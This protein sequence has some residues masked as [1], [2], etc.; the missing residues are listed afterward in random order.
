[1][2][3]ISRSQL[4]PTGLPH[5]QS[6]PSA[7]SAREATRGA[8]S[9]QAPQLNEESALG[10]PTDQDQPNGSLERPSKRVRRESR[11]HWANTNSKSHRG[12]A[13]AGDR[14]AARTPASQPHGDPIDPLPDPENDERDV[15]DTWSEQEMEMLHEL[16]VDSNPH[17]VAYENSQ[18]VDTLPLAGHEV[19][20]LLDPNPDVD[21]AFM[22]AFC[23][24]V[25]RLEIQQ[26]EPD[27]SLRPQS[28]ELI[29][30]NATVNAA[31]MK[32]PL[33]T[34]AANTSQA[35]ALL[36][37]LTDL[38][39]T[40]KQ[41]KA[42]KPEN[43][44]EVIKHHEALVG[45]RFNH[46][47]IVKISQR[48]PSLAYVANEEPLELFY[49]LPDLTDDQFLDM[50][51]SRS[52]NFALEELL[53]VAQDLKTGPLQLNTAQLVRIIVMRGARPA[54][55]AVHSLGP[56]LIGQPYGLTSDQVVKIASNSGGQL[57][58]MAVKDHLIELTS[59]PYSLELKDVVKIA[60]YDGGQLALKAVKDHLLELT[61]EPYFLEPKD[62][63]NI[64]SKKGGQLALKAVKD[65]LPELTS[66]PYSGQ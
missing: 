42:I 58:L 17:E 7:S 5:R 26:E 4:N 27:I 63:V 25:S 14:A 48:G 39:Y 20:T 46:A 52:G 38:G 8:S 9:P 40:E 11:P 3:P 12:A 64:A 53:R 31:G 57:A 1:M 49:I 66:D 22:D 2:S 41:A 45:L 19:D 50:A 16:L 6:G 36:T 33:E 29:A 51:N 47:Q 23:D 24:Q 61:S 10:Q 59:P 60:S 44:S 13:A 28:D 32:R 43:R 21:D 65:H 30:V 35:E 62:V 34:P 56:E 55:Q 15:E 18:L 54:L 37:P